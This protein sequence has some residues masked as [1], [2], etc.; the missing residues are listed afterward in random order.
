MDPTSSSIVFV[1][2]VALVTFTF[3]LLIV[4][5]CPF[6][7]KQCLCAHYFCR[8]PR[9]PGSP[10]IF[11]T[12]RILKDM[13]GFLRE[14]H[15]AH[16]DIFRTYLFHKD[17]VCVASIEYAKFVYG[18]CDIFHMQYETSLL[19]GFLIVKNG[20]DHRRLR[21]YVNHALNTTAPRMFIRILSY[22]IL[23]LTDV[24]GEVEWYPLIKR[25]LTRTMLQTILGRGS[26]GDKEL[27]RVMKRTE[28]ISNAVIST[29]IPIPG[30]AYW[31]GLRAKS[32][33][34]H[35]F[36]CS[37]NNMENLLQ[38][39]PTSNEFT[40]ILQSLLHGESTK[41]SGDEERL[42]RDEIANQCIFF[43]LASV[44][45]TSS[46]LGSILGEFRFGGSDTSENEF[47]EKIMEEQ[48][49]AWNNRDIK[50]IPEPVLYDKLRYELPLLG[51]L[52]REALR[53]YAP[54]AGTMRV[55]TKDCI[56]P[57]EHGYYI[58][59]GTYIC[60]SHDVAF[61]QNRKD[62]TKINPLRDDMGVSFPFGL[63]E[64]KCPGQYM[65]TLELKLILSIILERGWPNVKKEPCHKNQARVNKDDLF[66]HTPALQYKGGLTLIFPT[67]KM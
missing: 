31:K 62:P 51:A 39:H 44:D 58:E 53:A 2:N 40:S 59:K 30:T 3:C 64:H 27:S 41:V 60:V 38:E 45:T 5:L 8:E 46:I 15:H 56:L 52:I 29:P 54:F 65:V 34:K 48:R 63:G 66:E 50:S 7:V 12:F 17:I 23:E 18:Q 35:Y 47:G 67:A 36:M 16:G 25:I 37:I 33:L 28:L 9:I 13:R 6:T 14:Q 19:D 49:K 24:R 20:V 1:I 22:A 10:S 11:H 43:L 21:G 57:G 26:I 32:W 42:S 55:A 61:H 4:K